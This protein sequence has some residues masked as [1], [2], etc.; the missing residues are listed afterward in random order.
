[1]AFVFKSAKDLEKPIEK[2]YDIISSKRIHKIKKNV[3]KK[4][5]SNHIKVL[6]NYIIKPPLPRKKSAFGSSQKRDILNLNLNQDS[7]GPGSYD[8][9]SNIIKKSFNN[10]N[11]SYNNFNCIEIFDF[12]EKNLN[13][14]ISK[15]ERFKN[16]INTENPGPGEYNLIKLSN[17]KK[18]I[19]NK[20]FVVQKSRR[21][22]ANSPKR[23]ISIPS[24]GNDCGYFIDNKGE[25]ILEENPY[26]VFNEKNNIGPGS[27]N[28]KNNWIK[29]NGI[30]WSKNS[31]RNIKNNNEKYEMVNNLDL[32]ISQ[33]NN[34]KVRDDIINNNLNTEPR[35]ISGDNGKIINHFLSDENKKNNYSFKSDKTINN[36]N[37]ISENIN[38]DKNKIHKNNDI[39][40]DENLYLLNKNHYNYLR[41]LDD[42]YHR[43]LLNH[44]L[45]NKPKVPG[46]GNY[47]LL[48][49]FEKLANYQKSQ[50]FGSSSSRGLLYSN[51]GNKI[52]IRKQKLDKNLKI[53]SSYEKAKNN[54]IK[55]DLESNNIIHESIIKN[56]VNK[57]S[58]N[59]K[60]YKPKFRYITEEVEKNTKNDTSYYNKEINHDEEENKKINNTNIN[61]ENFGSLEKRFFEKPIKE[62]TPGVGTY[63]L[64]K[65]QE[66]CLNKYKN[67]SPY[68]NIKNLKKNKISD[69]M[70]NK[71]YEVNHRSPPIGLYSPELK[72]CIE[73]DC[74][75]KIELNN[76]RKVAFS[77]NEDRFFKLD[78]QK[79]FSNDF[80]KYNIIQEQIE[81]KQQKFPFLCG[82]EKNKKIK[83]LNYNS[84]DNNNKNLGP[85]KYRYE[86]YFDWIKKSFNKDFV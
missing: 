12:G 69:F 5:Q 39:Q 36:T 4:N 19:S 47:S 8:I 15:E 72:N 56:K 46:P 14:F 62:T 17:I 48:S 6:N 77:N 74:K 53:Y 68:K 50:N 2:E 34:I 85:G 23:D 22:L 27:Y 82:E 51:K 1:M 20:K 80:C 79:N 49:E 65:T 11:S 26:Y 66:N 60:K 54:S 71:I 81:M 40:Q 63:S 32:L 43:E 30:D 84:G 7:P 58:I 44:H 16:Y 13:C 28:I 83:I 29:N 61:I 67:N 37:D 9:N 41:I 55:E 18:N 25:K 42:E 78:N 64:V 21:F 45:Q 70:K 33:L 10:I 52:K 35:F 86:S 31:S 57:S 38:N 73:Y 75:K 3:L 59:L 76:G 24:K